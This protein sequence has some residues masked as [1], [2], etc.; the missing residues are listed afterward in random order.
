MKS[1]AAVAFAAVFALAACVETASQ[2]AKTCRLQYPVVCEGGNLAGADFANRDL[3][4]S[5]MPNANLAG[6]DFSGATLRLAN[7]VGADLRRADFS[8]ADLSSA[9]LTGANLE[10][11]NLEG[12]NLAGAIL[13]GAKNC[14]PKIARRCAE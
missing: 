14:P 10:G 2:A 4:V 3:T 12:A 13:K 11:A 8:A 6:A 1:L 7:L 5:H 9:F